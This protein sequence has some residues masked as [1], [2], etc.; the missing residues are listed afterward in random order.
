M[1][2]GDICIELYVYKVYA[3]CRVNTYKVIYLEYLL[4][5]MWVKESGV[6]M[7]SKFIFRTFGL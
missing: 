7:A 2:G 5:N 4:S 1:Y 3:I 6:F